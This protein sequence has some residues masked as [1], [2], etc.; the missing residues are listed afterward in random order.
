MS[1]E[2]TA[3]VNRDITLVAKQYAVSGLSPALK[4]NCADRVVFVFAALATVAVHRGGGH[5]SRFVSAAAN[6]R[7]LR[8][9]ISRK[10]HRPLRPSQRTA[11][12]AA[13]DPLAAVVPHPQPSLSLSLSLSLSAAV[14]RALLMS[15]ERRRAA[16][17]SLIAPTPRTVCMPTAVGVLLSL[18]TAIQ[19]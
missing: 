12:A 11:P 5:D 19:Y 14:S 3:L 16:L 2:R 13:H 18:L 8:A 17:S 10:R 6:H 9:D 1:S 15:D 4:T 7:I